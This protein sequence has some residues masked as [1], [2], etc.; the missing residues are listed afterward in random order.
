MSDLMKSYLAGKV[1]GTKV[2]YGDP[3]SLLYRV[4]TS[5][6]LRETIAFASATSG[7]TVVDQGN[8]VTID[9][10]GLATLAEDKPKEF[11]N[12]VFRIPHAW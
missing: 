11:L 12:K 4:D 7:A 2:K 1:P 9:G 6:G 5:R 3:R 10:G 8:G